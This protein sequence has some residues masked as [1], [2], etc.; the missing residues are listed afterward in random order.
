M[1][2]FDL[3]PAL[4]QNPR[5]RRAGLGALLCA[6]GAALAVFVGVALAAN[7]IKNGSFESDTNGDGM[8][9]KWSGYLLGPADKRVCN[10]SKAGNCSFRMVGNAAADK[11]LF[12]GQLA[13]SGGPGDTYELKVWVKTK[14]FLNGAGHAEISLTLY[15]TDDGNELYSASIDE[16][17]LG[18]TLYTLAF[19]ASE[20]YDG[21]L[22]Q[23][24]FFQVTGKAWFDKVKLVGP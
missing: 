10:Q 22:V 23:V 24:E 4:K 18:W 13:I 14:D 7:P 9:N 20:S 21:A 12:Q 1:K 19:A 16:G 15:Q 17:T 5:A 3:V 8:P 11:F 2:P 6:F